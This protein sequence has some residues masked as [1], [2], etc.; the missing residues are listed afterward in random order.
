MR[1]WVNLTLT[2]RASDRYKNL[3]L[4]PNSSV[5]EQAEAENWQRTSWC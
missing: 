5:L 3:P 4:I 1:Q 2:G